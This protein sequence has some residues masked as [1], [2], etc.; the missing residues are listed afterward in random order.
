[1]EEF[2]GWSQD[3]FKYLEAF[4][5]EAMQAWGFLHQGVLITESILL[6]VKGE[7]KYFISS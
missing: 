7:F 3:F 1:L 2:E 5:S 4:F 6:L